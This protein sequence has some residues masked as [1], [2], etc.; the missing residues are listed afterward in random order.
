M[1]GWK[2][3]LRMRWT[4]RLPA[5][6]PNRF[7][8]Y[9]TFRMIYRSRTAA[10]KSRKANCIEPDA[11]REDAESCSG[12]PRLRFPRSKIAKHSREDDQT[13]ELQRVY[14][15]DGLGIVSHHRQDQQ[16]E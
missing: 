10:R 3:W 13:A 9:S 6:G 5:C 1:C 15:T 2:G 7:P 16:R 4:S 8:A 12:S 14:G 11:R